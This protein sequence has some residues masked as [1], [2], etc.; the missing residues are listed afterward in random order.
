MPKVVRFHEFGGPEVL[1]LE[2]HD[3]GAPGPG[4]VLLDVEAIGLNRSEANFRRDRYLDRAVALPT[5]LGYEGAGRILATGPDVTGWRVGD[6]VSVIPLFHQS[7]Y[8]M[9]GEQAVV[10]ASSLVTRAASVSAVDGAATWMPFLTA[11]GALVDIGRLRSGG[12]VVITAASSSVGLGAIQIARR[13][14]AIPIATTNDSGKSQRLLEAGAAH[15]LVTEE[16]DLT[17]SILDLTGGR[18]ADMVFDAVAGPGVEALV[19]ATAPEG[20]LF[21]HGKLSGQPTPL[22]GL[23]NMRPVYTRPYTVFE[24]TGDLQRLAQAVDYIATSIASN[25]LRPVIDRIFTLDDIVDAHRYLE[26]G[27]QVGK[28]VVTT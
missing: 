12:H 6:A 14:G 11:Y 7:R 1:Q 25:E 9:Y 4:E 15:V 3:P 13:I 18:G 20:V 19:A 24:I 16:D 21:V 2:E 28:I 23:A 22:P 5:G 26:A 17:A 8:H 27:T 10:P